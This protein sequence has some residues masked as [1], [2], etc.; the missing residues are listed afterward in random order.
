MKTLPKKNVPALTWLDGGVCAPGGF[1]ANGIYCGIKKAMDPDGGSPLDNS[2]NDLMLLCADH[3]CAAAAV[4]TQNKVQGAPVLSMKSHLA[5]T[6]GRARAVIA[7]SKN[8]NTCNRD[9]REK[10]E[11]MC[12]LAGAA[13]GVDPKEVMVMSTGVIGQALPLEPME[14]GLPKLCAALGKTPADATAAAVAIMTTDTFPKEIAAE[15]TV[16]GTPCRIGGMAKGSGMIHPNMATTLSI[17]TTNVAISPAMLQKILSE[18]VRETLNTLSIDG[19]ESTNDTCLILA[20]GDA[21]NPEII[22]ECAAADDFRH[23]LRGILMNLTRMLAFDGEGATKLLECHVTG[24][25]TPH[26]AITLAKSVISSP[27]VK[28]AMFGAD[29]NYGRVLCAL[30]YADAAL[31]PEH[32]TLRFRSSAG[33]ILVCENGFG[34]PF[35]EKLAKAILSEDEIEILVGLRDGS[36]SAAAYGCD[37]TYDYVKIN[38]DYRS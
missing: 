20:S 34:V 37:L 19:D 2:K 29:A 13:L 1:S 9:G 35:S 7:N 16:Q 14:K 25:K 3:T 18:T 27:L 33:E 21:G 22:C 6:E 36:C 12:D 17:L 15:F 31:S 5:A 4:F 28:T 24:A 10:A 32:V 26:D 38:G 11:R 23:A 8:A 30:G